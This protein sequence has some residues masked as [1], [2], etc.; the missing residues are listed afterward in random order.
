M[1][2]R[3]IA[4]LKKLFSKKDSEPV[5]NLFEYNGFRIPIDLVNLTGGGVDTWEEISLGHQDQLEKYSPIDPDHHV[6]EVGCGVGRD[7]IQLTSHLSANGSYDGVDIIKPSI[8]W[9]QNNIT[10]RFSNF[11]FHYLD[12]YSQ[13]HNAGG[14]LKTTDVKLPVEDHSID[15]IILHSVFT[16]MFEEDIV[17]YLHEFERILKPD[18][19]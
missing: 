15:R 2:E 17:Y 3:M 1:T 4:V 18:G 11:R 16:H 5:T 13:I 6:L 14:H 9:C 19:K 7:A 8:E 10:S 12:I